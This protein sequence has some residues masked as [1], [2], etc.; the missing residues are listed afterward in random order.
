MIRLRLDDSIKDLVIVCGSKTWRTQKALA[1][2][3][4]GFFELACKKGFAHNFI[5]NGKGLFNR[6]FGWGDQ[7]NETIDAVDLSDDDPVL[8]E[9]MMSYF[10]TLNWEATP[11]V[12][13]CAHEGQEHSYR[14]KQCRLYP[15]KLSIAMHAFAEKYDMQGLKKMAVA[16]FEASRWRRLKAQEQLELTEDVYANTREVDHLRKIVRERAI[17]HI[18][19]R[20]KLDG[21]RDFILN[22]PGFAYDAIAVLAVYGDFERKRWC[23]KCGREKVQSVTIPACKEGR[24]GHDRGME[25]TI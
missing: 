6:L 18:K 12:E 23:A 4:S 13:A 20:A 8:I 9:H 25:E 19:S 14:I 1:C 2:A 7:A 3:H 21:F 16:R 17:D 5:R 15:A 24:N 11:F 22:T 10:Y